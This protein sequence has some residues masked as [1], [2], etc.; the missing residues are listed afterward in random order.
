MLNEISQAEKINY[1]MVSLTCG[2]QGITWRTLGEGKEKLIGGNQRG[3]QSMRDWTQTVLE[4]GGV[5]RQVSL[6]MGIKEGTYC[7]EHWVWC[8]NNEYCYAEKKFL[9]K[10]WFQIV[11]AAETA[12]KVRN[13]A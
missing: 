7:M 6:A 1:H 10:G 4:G 2:A 3:K 8:K 11:E 12:K 13:S 9:K 5:E